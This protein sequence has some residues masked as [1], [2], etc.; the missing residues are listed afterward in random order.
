MEGERR[1]RREEKRECDEKFVCFCCAT[2]RD[3]RRRD[4]DVDLSDAPDVV[5]P[6]V[7]LVEDDLLL[8][9][10]RVLLA[11]ALLLLRCL[12]VAR[13]FLCRLEHGKDGVLVADISPAHG[14]RECVG[15]VALEWRRNRQMVCA[16]AAE[17][18]HELLL[19]KRTCK[20][21]GIW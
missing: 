13:L 16:V 20:R 5:Q 19:L 17:H 12:G 21:F 9:P 11:P 8:Y 15:M 6:Q 2:L 4:V 18:V 7:E 10:C 3:E 14:L 1:K